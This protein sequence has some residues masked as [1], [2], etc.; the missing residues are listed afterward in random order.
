MSIFR[1]KS[2]IQ[3]Q[4]DKVA[5]DI[6]NGISDDVKLREIQEREELKQKTWASM[7][8]RLKRRLLMYIKEHH[9]EK[10]KT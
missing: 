1:K 9:N 3:R 6:R 10:Q 7:S 2:E 5:K 8:P 4:L